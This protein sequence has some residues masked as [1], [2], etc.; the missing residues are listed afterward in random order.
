MQN[1]VTY[2]SSFATFLRG[3]VSLFGGDISQWHIHQSAFSGVTLEDGSTS[4]D[5]VM[6]RKVRGNWV[7]RRPTEDEL[8]DYD[9]GRAW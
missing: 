5:V 1:A 4:K 2:K 8:A 7:Y 9:Q 6:R 3:L